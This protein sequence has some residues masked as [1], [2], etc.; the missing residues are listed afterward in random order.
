MFRRIGVTLRMARV[1][2]RDSSGL[3]ESGA[4]GILEGVSFHAI[5][6][7]GFRPCVGRGAVLTVSIVHHCV[8]NGLTLVPQEVVEKVAYSMD[9][10]EELAVSKCQ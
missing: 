4:T 8:S 7:R 1:P 2:N 3:G 10:V 5:E 6:S 9:V